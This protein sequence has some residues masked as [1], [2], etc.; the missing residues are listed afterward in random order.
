METVK[1]GIDG[2]TLYDLVRVARQ[3]V[4][5]QPTPEAEEQILKTRKLIENWVETEKTIYGVTTGFGLLSEVAISKED[6][7][8]EWSPFL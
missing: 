6:K 4:K 2:M 5:A 8:R 1:I 7:A 3:G